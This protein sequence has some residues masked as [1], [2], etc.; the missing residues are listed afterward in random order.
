ML[1]GDRDGFAVE[2][3]L[4]QDF[5]RHWLQGRACFWIQGSPIGDFQ[6]EVPLCDVV[7]ALHYLAWDNGRRSGS[8]YCGRDPSLAF[9]ALYASLVQGD[10]TAETDGYPACPSLNVSLDVPPFEA[11]TL[12][13]LDCPTFSRLLVGRSSHP[14]ADPKLIQV[15][16]LR[17]GEYDE[18]IVE[19]QSKLNQIQA[20]LQPK[21]NPTGKSNGRS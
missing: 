7:G 9:A 11:W 18:V 8:P 10:D 20:P 13:L 2:W 14:E 21:A 17:P 4:N 16:D 5:D 15:A 6:R 3:Q 12:F 19:F 1:I